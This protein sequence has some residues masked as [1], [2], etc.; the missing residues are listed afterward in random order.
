MTDVAVLVQRIRTQFL[1]MRG[2]KLTVAQGCRLWNISRPVCDQAF[3]QLLKEEFLDRTASGAF[4]A[5]PSVLSIAKASV[6]RR[7]A[8]PATQRPAAR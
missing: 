4:V 2:L 8:N 3:E 7:D 6:T 5:L 1:E